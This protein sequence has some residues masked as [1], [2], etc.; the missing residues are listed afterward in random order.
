MATAGM[1]QLSTDR[2]PGAGANRTAP[3]RRPRPALIQYNDPARKWASVTLLIATVLLFLSVNGPW[4]QATYSSSTAGTG[5]L[6]QRATVTFHVGGTV[7]CATYN[8]PASSPCQNVS[9][10]QVGWRATV[11]SGFNAVLL[12]LFFAAAGSW[13]LATLGNVGIRFARGQLLVEVALVLAVAVAALGLLVGS[14]ALG[15]GPQAGTYCWYFSGNITTCPFYWGGATAGAIPGACD[16]CDD[17]ISWGAGAAYYETLAATALVGG[18]GVYLWR[19]RKGPYLP[20]EVAAWSVRNAP[21][22]IPVESPPPLAAAAAPTPA[23]VNAF[24]AVRPP[25]S[26]DYHGFHIAESPW[27]C[28]QCQSVNSRFA[29]QCRTCHAERPRARGSDVQA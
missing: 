21:F 2:S 5:G 3:A 4:W 19:G 29:L 28:A 22:S 8:W 17:A 6:V 14:V 20:E 18:T 13:T 23:P 1:S 27:T 7:T 12:G 9:S 10:E 25:I 16:L 26:E 24:T 11:S 15:P